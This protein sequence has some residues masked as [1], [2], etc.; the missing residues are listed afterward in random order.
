MIE[1]RDA[2]RHSGLAEAVPA[3][4]P[5]EDAPALASEHRLTV[6]VN[7]QP[8][9]RITCTPSHLAELAAGRLLTEGLI[10]EAA[11][12]RLMAVCEQGLT[13]RVFLREGLALRP[14]ADP[15]VSVSTCC[16]DTRTLAEVSGDLP[17][18]TPAPWEAGWLR[19]LSARLRGGEPLYRQ[20]R[21]VHACFLSRGEEV[22]CSREDIGRHNALDKAV[23]YGLIRE[24]DL[25]ACWLFTT[26]RMPADMVS[27]AVRAG[28]PLLVSKTYPTVEGL[29]I[30][31]RA[32]L[33]LVTLRGDG[34]P[35]VWTER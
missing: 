7:E 25:G 34:E 6:F 3:P 13:C 16:T 26:G 12:I 9:M 20:T 14:S 32:G 27:K 33:T 22:L 28:I 5:R 18:V 15:A 19:A 1:I 29:A 4:I 2:S 30:A 23:G 35:L 21:A 11:D 8:A 17:A 31:R 24:I 10:R